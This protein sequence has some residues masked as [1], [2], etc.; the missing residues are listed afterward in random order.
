MPAQFGE[1]AAVMRAAQPGEPDLRGDIWTAFGDPLLPE[2]IR[3]TESG[4]PDLEFAKARYQQAIGAQAQAR[5][6]WFPVFSGT[7]S[8]ARS[9]LNQAVAPAN[10][11]NIGVAATW[12]ADLWGRIGR[13]VESANAN[14]QALAADLAAARLSLQAQLASTYASLRIVD[15]Q[16]QLLEQAVQAFDRSLQLTRNRYAAG[17]ANR[18]DVAQAEAQLHSTR[19]QLIDTGVARA[20]LEHAVAALI[21]KAP[22]HYSLP[23]K[24]QFTLRLPTPATLLPSQMLER[25]PDI[26]AAERRMAAANAQ[27]GVAEA[28]FFPRLTFNANDGFRGSEISDL[29]NLPHRIWSVGPTLALTLFDAGA[30]RAVSDQA[31]AGYDQSVAQY[32]QTVLVA[33]QE[34]EDNLAALRVLANEAQELELA[35]KAAQL[36]TELALNQYKAGTV[37]YLNVVTAQTTDLNAR[38][39]LLAVQG[40]R[41][42]ALVNLI[43]ALGGGW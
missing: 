26:A 7:T 4:S 24:S 28:A 12:E 40:Q 22:A 1:A 17:V 15:A 18:S 16:S 13:S 27:I 34:V 9:R 35:V 19:A 10:V 39:T 31:R 38:R 20:Q 5:A 8:A 23:V 2:L 30:R 14:A 37:S 33:M 43:K 42:A 36:A 11:F 21:G 41:F 29:I 6:G 25:R 32:R 3:Q